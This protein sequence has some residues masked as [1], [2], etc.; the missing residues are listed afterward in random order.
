MSGAQAERLVS[1]QILRGVAAL[2]VVSAHIFSYILGAPDHS[3]ILWFARWRYFAAIGVD[4]F[5]VIS[6]FVMALSMAKYEGRPVAFLGQRWWR[7]APLAYVVAAVT[8]LLGAPYSPQSAFSTLTILPLA[9]TYT[10][11]F[12]GVL[13]TLSF[14]FAFYLLVA[15]ALSLKWNRWQLLGFVCALASVGLFWKAPVA[16]LRWFTH[17]ILF[18][19]ALGIL[20]FQL[21][22]KLSRRYLTLAL[23]AGCALMLWQLF[24]AEE[25][26]SHRLLTIHG[27]AAPYRALVWGLPTFLLF[28]VAVHWQP[29][30]GTLTR[31]GQALGDASYS[32]YLIHAILLARCFQFIPGPADVRYFLALLLTVA[33]AQLVYILVERPIVNLPKRLRSP[34]LH[35]TVAGNEAWNRGAQ[36]I[37][38]DDPDPVRL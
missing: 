34:A 35:P 36:S 33:V 9:R 23:V 5:F 11:P 24:T 28:V 18:E 15:F 30:A 19:F 20:A 10:E 32:L 8:V 21:R 31:L 13:W 26:M 37:V 38:E 29:K 16:L 2:L 27:S 14:E 3:Y 6:G 22:G 7:I 17:P 12:V 25:W 4:I 1:V